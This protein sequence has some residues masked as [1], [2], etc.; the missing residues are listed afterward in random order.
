MNCVP[1]ESEAMGQEAVY[2]ESARIRCYLLVPL[3]V[4][5]AILASANRPLLHTPEILFS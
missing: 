3:P 2:L 1:V 5:G 4:P